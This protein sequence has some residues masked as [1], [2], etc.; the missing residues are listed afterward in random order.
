M[1]SVS[2]FMA[3]VASGMD[4]RYGQKRLCSLWKS[5]VKRQ[6]IFYRERFDSVP[7]L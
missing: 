4:D 5:V 7:K 1:V 2:L 6:E 3:L